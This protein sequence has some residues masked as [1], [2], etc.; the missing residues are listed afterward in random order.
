MI[1]KLGPLP[2]SPEFTPD[3]SWTLLREPSLWGFQLRAIPIALFTTVVLACLW[4]ILTPVRHVMGTL[5]F[6]LPISTFFAC[7]LGVIVIHELIHASVHPKIGIS[8]KT[9]I[10]FWP[11]RM[12]VY[13]IYVGE[14]TK[15]RCLA[16]LIMPF[17]VISIIPLA[18][19]TITQTASFW[20]AYISILNGLLACGDILAA[21]MT[22]RLF[23]NGA[24][25]RTKGWLTFWKPR[26]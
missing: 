24:I 5:T 12:F 26:K 25:I 18:F 1:F 7:L 11:S 17:T 19:A 21:V 3:D 2:E 9:V 20:V 8:E 23:P 10:G 16:I 22:L 6:P 13:T 14:L 4:I 15:N